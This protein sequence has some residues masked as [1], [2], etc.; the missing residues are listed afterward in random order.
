[1]EYVGTHFIIRCY[2]PK[3]L[4]LYCIHVTVALQIAR[5]LCPAALGPPAEAASM[6]HSDSNGPSLTQSLA[7]GCAWRPWAVSLASSAPAVLA[8]LLTGRPAD[9]GEAALSAKKMRR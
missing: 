5:R 3:N 1:M 6:S 7:W 2:Y 9:A 8:R 4:G